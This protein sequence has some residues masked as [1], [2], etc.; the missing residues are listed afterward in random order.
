MAV[1]GKP[2]NVRSVNAEKPRKIY[3]R[4]NENHNSELYTR[5]RLSALCQCLAQL[6]A[7]ELKQLRLLDTKDQKGKQ[8]Q[9]LG[10][11]T[12]HDKDPVTLL[13]GMRFYS[14]VMLWN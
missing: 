7:P 2:I 12:A 5:Q 6:C 11:S 14:G 8:G 10:D 4:D 3:N 13:M 1:S 9:R